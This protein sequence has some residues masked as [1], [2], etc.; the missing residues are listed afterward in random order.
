MTSAVE[1]HR[2]LIFLAHHSTERRREMSG[3]L[4]VQPDT[5]FA[6]PSAAGAVSAEPDAIRL[7]QLTLPSLPIEEVARCRRTTAMFD[8][9]R[10]LS[11]AHI[12]SVLAAATSGSLPAETD[13]HIYI[14]LVRT[15]TIPHATY[16]YDRASH[17][18]THVAPPLERS[19]RQEWVWQVEVA[20]AAAF[21]MI[22]CDLRR[23]LARYGN[24]GYRYL[25]LATGIVFEDI[26][27]AVTALGIGCRPSGSWAVHDVETY[28]GLTDGTRLLTGLIGLGNPK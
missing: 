2:E 15:D 17:S 4:A 14:A 13:I 12:G 10:A 26:Y 5:I 1:T 19:T 11:L 16:R 22:T 18:L 21:L 28:L 24:R 9:E 20:D 7:P 23:S 3:L 8:T 27:L 6:E 25:N